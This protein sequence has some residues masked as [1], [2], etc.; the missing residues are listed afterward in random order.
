MPS[1][2][3]WDD[4][5]PGAVLSSAAGAVAPTMPLANL[6]DA[7]P[8]MRARWLGSEAAVL[9]DF[10]ADTPVE[11]VGLISTSLRASDVVRV[12]HGDIEGLI[13]APAV[14]D[15]RFTQPGSLV[16]PA[17]WTFLRASVAQRFNEAGNLEQVASDVLRF[18]HDPGT[19]ACK[20]ILLEETRTNRIRNP[21][22]EGSAAGSPGTAPTDWTIAADNGIARTI[23]GSGM[24][25][26][27]PYVDVR[28]SG[29]ATGAA[30]LSVALV[31]PLGAAA[32][33]GQVWTGSAFLRL[34]AG[35]FGTTLQA[36]QWIIQ[37][38]NGIGQNIAQ[39]ASVLNPAPTGGALAT[40]RPAF[41]RTLTNA[42]TAFV[43][44]V[45]YTQYALGA[46]VDFTLRIGAPQLELGPAVSSPILPPVGVI[47]S[48]F[49]AVE[50]AGI[51][52]LSIGEATLL[53]QC[54][55]VGATGGTLIPG[56]YAPPGSFA[57]A[58]YFSVNSNGTCSW[59]AVSG[60]VGTA[61]SRVGAA[62]APVTLVGAASAAGAR[63]SRNGA[64]A[65]HSNPYAVPAGMTRITLGAAPW[66][67]GLGNT[68]GTGTYQRLALYGSR[69][70][71]NQVEALSG[72]GSSLVPSS[73][74]WDSGEITADTADGWQGNV[75]VVAPGE[76][77]A[78]YLLVAARAVG[79]DAVDIGRLVAG[80]LWKPL[81]SFAY[82]A[83][84]GREILDQRD[85]NPLTG[86]EFPRPA[87]V[88]P[89]MQRFT[90]PI[91]SNAE[92]RASFRDML[93]RLAGA[94][95]ALWI[96]ELSLTRAE[97]NARSL[98]GAIA[99]AGEEAV[100]TRDAP[101]ANSRTFRIVERV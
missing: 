25:S 11:A 63:F 22:A 100:A 38:Y 6:T 37:E 3:L 83:Q 95:E 92:L 87:L 89:R 24:E 94:R 4:R 40:Q 20:G 70:T 36:P 56:G 5:V 9:A 27:I 17:G 43:G 15:L 77:V 53:V 82:G 35:S 16:L 50:Q 65:G 7:Q 71:N 60:G 30:N 12:W 29:T 73:V 58:A 41:T 8:R 19:L 42:S 99:G 54:Q 62:N 85:R 76:S 79:A 1:A 46:V 33:S 69:L 88:N 45:F 13:E 59:T 23:V 32:A 90:L 72:T 74:V 34:V 96:P 67:A 57:N 44:L 47:G 2:F 98:W 21:R 97:M 66:G 68:T 84:E 81:R 61:L 75:V 52:G 10:G 55:T 80:P 51:V 91:L 93:V 78:R 49:R 28:F 48:T 64:S 18:D 14:L 101:Q 86:A 39:G 26:G 31:N